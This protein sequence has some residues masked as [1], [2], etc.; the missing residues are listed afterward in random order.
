MRSEPKWHRFGRHHWLVKP[1]EGM[2][3][4]KQTVLIRR[5]LSTKL[6]GAQYSQGE[7]FRRARRKMFS[8]QPEK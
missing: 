2:T 3:L 5:R 4:F 6:E 1:R 7:D 8:G